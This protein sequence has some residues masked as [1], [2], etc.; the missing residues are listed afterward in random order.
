M[1]KHRAP[2]TPRTSRH[3]LRRSTVLLP[4]LALLCFGVVP[5]A[6]AA[7]GNKPTCKTQ[8]EI[9]PSTWTLQPMTG[10]WWYVK[11]N[12]N[13][14]GG[15]TG[16]W[17]SMTVERPTVQNGSLGWHSL[18]AMYIAT[19][20]SQGKV[21]DGVE[22]GWAVSPKNYSLSPGEPHLFAF[23][24]LNGNQETKCWDHPDQCGWHE[25]PGATHHLGD[26]LQPQSGEHAFGIRFS[27]GNWQ[28]IFDQQ[29]IGWF[30]G[31]HWKHT[32]LHGTRVSWYGEVETNSKSPD[33]TAMGNGKYGTQAGSAKIGSMGYWDRGGQ[34]HWSQ[35]TVSTPSGNANF[36]D[37]G[38]HL[39]A[40]WMTYGGP[41]GST[42]QQGVDR[43]C[44]SGG[45]TTTPPSNNPPSNGGGT[46][47]EGSSCTTNGQQG[48]IVNGGCVP[49]GVISLPG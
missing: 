18:A 27:G 49:F 14:S 13:P 10:C 6:Q 7:S 5:P 20:D 42:D 24:D 1:A 47:A 17:S 19:L 9:S 16:V 48:V 8:Y 37:M 34:F 43:A 38:N 41:G 33:C 2:R 30:D 12:D 36:Y 32:F 44:G 23:P 21:Y 4:L 15:V 25:A 31:S 11:A 35:P 22:V 28:V 3:R 45:G 29:V 26:Q 39:N 46:P 40:S